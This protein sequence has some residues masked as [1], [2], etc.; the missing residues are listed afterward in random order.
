MPNPFSRFQPKKNKAK[1]RVA[2]W[3]SWEK[4][5]LDRR[6]LLIRIILVGMAVLTGGAILVMIHRVSSARESSMEMMPK[7]VSTRP[8]QLVQPF[9]CDIKSGFHSGPVQTSVKNVGNAR[10]GSV[11]E[12]LTLRLVPERKVGIADFDNLPHGDCSVRPLVKPLANFLAAG[13]NLDRL[14]PEPTVALPPLLRGESV[15]LYALSCIYYSEESGTQHSDCETRRF[16]PSSGTPEFLCD[17][18]PGAGTFEALP[19]ASCGN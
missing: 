6:F 7:V 11:I 3:Q 16:R 4:S 12:T 1:K 18:T 19:V 5:A 14:L 13:Q 9:I 8:P 15:Q 10:A 17:N 2:E